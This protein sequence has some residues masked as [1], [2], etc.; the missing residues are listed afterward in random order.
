[1]EK[2]Q[3]LSERLDRVVD[4]VRG[5]GRA[6]AFLGLG[7]IGLETA[8]MDEFSDLDF[9]VI[10]RDG[11]KPWFLDDLRWLQS[12]HPVAFSYRNTVDG[13]KLLYTDGIL[14]E[15]AIFEAHELRRIPFSRGRI[16]WSEEGFDGCLCLPDPDHTK[17]ATSSKEWL[18]GEILTNLF[19]GLSRNL[20]GETLSAERL[21]QVNVVDRL[22]ELLEKEETPTTI[23][24]DG[25]STER[26]LEA[27]FPM[28]RELLP[29]FMQGYDRNI[30]SARE[31]VTYLDTRYGIGN[32]VKNIL[33][34]KLGKT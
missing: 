30:E 13:H 9:F 18:M 33:L 15:F 7:S 22:V 8:R 27:R 10:A 23:P 32:S 12:V 21:I 1:M 24:R 28:T 3:I 2:K 34:E 31:I 29:R 19:V 25:F 6:R 17:T 5:S 20:R 16:L 4:A 14:C 11:E 26:R